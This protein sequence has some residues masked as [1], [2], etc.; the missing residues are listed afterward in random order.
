MNTSGESTQP[1]TTSPQARCF[2][3]YNATSRDFDRVFFKP[4][5]HLQPI[6]ARQPRHLSLSKKR[7]D[8]SD[9]ETTSQS[10]DLGVME[11]VPFEMPY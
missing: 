6:D 9:R 4:M 2:F 7:S 11:F 3:V 5:A 8:L 10:T 1:H